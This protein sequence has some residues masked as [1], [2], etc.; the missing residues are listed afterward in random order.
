M[1]LHR[2]AV[3][4]SG[5]AVLAGLL[6]APP[7]AAVPA[8][9]RESRTSIDLPDGFQ[10][11]GIATGPR[12]QAWF[13]S[14]ADGDI[15]RANL[16]TGVGS[17]ISEGPGPG[18]PSVGLDLDRRGRLFV[19][20]GS[21]GDAR[22]VDG[23]SGDLL[24]R[25][26]LVEGPSFVNDVIATRRAA[27]FTDSFNAHLI[28]VPLK[29]H[30]R[31]AGQRKVKR[32]PLWGDWVQAAD[33]FNANG[34]ATVP[35]GRALLVVNSSSG[36]LFRV[37]A[38]TGHASMVDLRGAVLTNGDGLLREGRTLYVVQNLLNQVAVLRLA[39]DGRSGRLMWTFSAPSFD[40]PTTVA[41]S[42]DALYLPN[43]RFAT[44]PEPDTSYWATRVPI[45]RTPGR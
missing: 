12:H 17:V 42:G 25:Y 38:R 15:Y 2:P 22:V 19:A 8:Q 26:Q 6:V 43:A 3:L 39:N 18:S 13:G 23:D 30:G 28:K 32:I 14:L 20:G 9:E 33:T 21:A 24:R 40:V 11:E 7:T 45:P 10:P 34:I 1:R 29:R 44:P 16:K 31:L 4:V 36:E 41:R 35:R 37:N 27:W 5:L